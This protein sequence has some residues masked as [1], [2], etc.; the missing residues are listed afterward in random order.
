[1]T[2][3]LVTWNGLRWLPDCLTSVRDQL[4]DDVELLVV[5]NG[6]TDGTAEWLELQLASGTSAPLVRNQRNEGYAAAHDA[7]LARARGEFVLLLDQDVVLDRGFLGATIRAFRAHPDVGA[8]QGRLRRLE[9][10]GSRSTVLDSTGLVMHRDR[11]VTSRAQGDEESERHRVAG[12]V[13]GADGPAPVYRA[14]ALRET[15]LSRPEGG[16]E[17][18][19]RDFFAYKEDVD[20]AWRLRRWGWSAWYE[21]EALAW[22]AR[23]ASVTL[24][25]GGRNMLKTR[26]ATPATVKILSWSNQRLMMAKNETWRELL[27]DLPWI[28]RRESLSMA[29]MVLF[30]REVLPA[31]PEL[32]RNLPRALRKR[33]Q[34]ARRLKAAGRASGTGTRDEECHHDPHARHADPAA[35]HDQLMPSHDGD[36]DG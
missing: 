28:I 27:R 18:L 16:W 4:L 20:L 6:S 13:W 30:D 35:Q 3:S 8:V 32:I 12:P 21:P 22:H 25:G 19:D 31:V 29:F 1:M 23:G 2:V 9:A 5:D 10:D 34:S 26:R 11:R 15:R 36:S 24:R 17:V 7:N 33:R 14:A